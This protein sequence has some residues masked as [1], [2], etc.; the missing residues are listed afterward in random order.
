MNRMKANISLLMLSLFAAAGSA[1]G[2]DVVADAVEGQ[3]P[4]LVQVVVPQARWAAVSETASLLAFAH[5]P[6][7]DKPG[8]LSIFGIDAEGNPVGTPGVVPPPAAD[9][10][11][12]D[13]AAPAPPPPP[14]GPLFTVELPRPASLAA[15]P[16]SAACL[17]FH[18]TLPLL[19][20]WQ[21]IAGPPLTSAMNN[22]VFA[23]FDH[24]LVYS[25]AA[26]QPPKLE[27][28]TARGPG[29][30]YGVA[31]AMLSLDPERKRL[32]VP[33]LRA[34]TSPDNGASGAV[35]YIK[36]DERGMPVIEEAQLVMT[37]ENLP[38]H[39][40]I[41]A[42]MGCVFV[43][44]QVAIFGGAYGPT[45]W[46]TGS[47]RGRLGGYFLG[48]VHV[49]HQR[50][51]GHPTL[52][53]VYLTGLATPFAFKVEHAHGY[54]T[55]QPQRLTV[56]GNVFLTPPVLMT[57]QNKIAF[58][59][60]LKILVADL[61]QAGNFAG[62]VTHTPVNNPAPDALTYSEK[63]DRLYVAIEPAP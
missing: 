18:P 23:E 33:N 45:T 1:R 47:K 44:D 52:P 35:G 46:D 50:L 11:P 15:F 17:L 51:V 30:M 56:N 39:A 63:F 12:P 61:D 42:G 57:K 2:A 7:A 6:V 10:P 3:I 16:N 22:P 54:L 62:P 19:Y 4:N 24:L 29:F 26:G 60:P 55:L 13:P 38:I 37:V 41:P 9:A 59:A 28:A 27:M 32:F 5:R 25:L 21:D 31:G 40:E 20:V 48:N 49:G 36:L 8:S 43:S 14:P 34:L 58:G 53:L